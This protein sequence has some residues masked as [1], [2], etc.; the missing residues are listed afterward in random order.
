MTEIQEREPHGPPTSDR[1]NCNEN[2]CSPESPPCCANGTCYPYSDVLS[3][4]SSNS[5]SKSLS[6]GTRA[7][8]ATALDQQQ[9]SRLVSQLNLA[10]RTQL[11]SAMMT[12]PRYWRHRKQQTQISTCDKAGNTQSS[13]SSQ[14]V[15]CGLAPILM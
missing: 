1:C 15:E 2:G 13:V 8:G 3:S 10:W 4:E 9:S 5:L 12:K 14:V 6:L 7:F 11:L